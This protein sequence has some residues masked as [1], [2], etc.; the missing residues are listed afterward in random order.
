MGSRPPLMLTPAESRALLRACGERDVTLED[1]AADGETD[2]KRER[3]ALHR[4]WKKLQVVHDKL[5][6]PRCR[7]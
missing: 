1:Q 4:A 2:A 3:A 7:T 5:N 6:P